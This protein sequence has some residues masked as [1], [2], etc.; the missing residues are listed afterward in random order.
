MKNKREGQKIVA[1]IP[2]KLGSTR[3]AMKNLALINGKPAIYYAIK[4][5]RESGIFSKI[6]INAEDAVFSKI[7]A[8]PFI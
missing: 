3:L 4:A 5:A 8:A 7:A 1:M 2:A 6:I